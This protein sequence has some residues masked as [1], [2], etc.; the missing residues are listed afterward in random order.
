M[1]FVHR[2]RKRPNERTCRH[3]TFW[4][5]NLPSWLPGNITATDLVQNVIPSHVKNVI[6]GMGKNLTSW[7][8]MNE[9]IGDN[10]NRSMVRHVVLFSIPL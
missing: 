9:I 4:H 3:N 1:R 7:D 6:F 10:V 8:V 5:N 2:W